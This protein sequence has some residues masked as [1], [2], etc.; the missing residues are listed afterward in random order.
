VN[1]ASRRR[2]IH[3][4][5][6]RS[7]ED[8]RLV[9][10]VLS[11]REPKWDR[12]LVTNL[13]EIPFIRLDF[14]ILTNVAT[15]SRVMFTEDFRHRLGLGAHTPRARDLDEDHLAG[16]LWAVGEYGLRESHF[17]T[18]ARQLDEHWYDIYN[19]NINYDSV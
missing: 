11:L 13:I 2:E 7:F 5:G 9:E 10:D 6:T 18:I 14:R 17:E 3:H 8:R 16:L 19:K 15:G 1:L 4:L 12:L